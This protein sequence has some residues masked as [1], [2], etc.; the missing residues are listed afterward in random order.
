MQDNGDNGTN[1]TFTVFLIQTGKNR[2][3][4]CIPIFQLR[5]DGN[6]VS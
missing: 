6:A 3:P 4:D 2:S 1:R 5:R